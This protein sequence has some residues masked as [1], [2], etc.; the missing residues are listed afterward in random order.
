[1]S[2]ETEQRI[3]G[4]QLPSPPK[5]CNIYRCKYSNYLGDYLEYGYL[6]RNLGKVALDELAFRMVP[7]CLGQCE[8]FNKYHYGRAVMEGSFLSFMAA[9]NKPD[10]PSPDAYLFTMNS[11]VPVADAVRG[12]YET[13]DQPKPALL[14]IR[15]K[16][17]HEHYVDVLADKNNEAPMIKNKKVVIVDQ[18]CDT[19]DT[20]ANAKKL[21]FA[22]GAKAVMTTS[23]HTRWYHQY[24]NDSSN[25][26]VVG[27]DDGHYN[28]TKNPELTNM[29]SECRDLMYSIGVTTARFLSVE[30]NQ[31]WIEPFT[32]DFRWEVAPVVPNSRGSG[33]MPN[34][35]SGIISNIIRSIRSK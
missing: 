16:R 3:E 29:T 25:E 28:M 13:L 7:V 35:M 21:A 11:A 31:A 32:K 5:N 10:M 17:S 30:G 8:L 33:A 1:M 15:G 6:Q 26:H 23:S 18:Y 14:P 2:S 19:G 27:H 9:T 22:A 4:A 34:R 12:Y 20:I 24:N